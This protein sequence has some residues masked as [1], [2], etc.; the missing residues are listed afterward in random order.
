MPRLDT[1]KMRGFAA[2]YETI[3][4]IHEKSTKQTVS[5][6]KQVPEQQRNMEKN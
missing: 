2:K 3:L 6:A 5:I 1:M 4:L